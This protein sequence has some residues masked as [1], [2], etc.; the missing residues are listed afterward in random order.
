MLNIRASVGIA[1]GKPCYNVPSDQQIVQ[2]LLSRIPESQGGT[3][4]Q[5]ELGC[6]TSEDCRV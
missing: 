6:T 2:Q 5:E 1:N 3:V 4:R